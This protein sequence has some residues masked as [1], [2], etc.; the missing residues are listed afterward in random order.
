MEA[1]CFFVDSLCRFLQFVSGCDVLRCLLRKARSLDNR[2]ICGE[3]LH[4]T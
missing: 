1:L 4:H 3:F 2:L